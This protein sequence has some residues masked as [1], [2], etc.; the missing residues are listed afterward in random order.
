MHC[1]KNLGFELGRAPLSC[2]RSTVFSQSKERGIVVS[3]AIYHIS[4]TLVQH[5]YIRAINPSSRLYS[6]GY[7]T[8][9]FAS[10]F[11]HTTL[12]YTHIYLRDGDPTRTV[13]IKRIHDLGKGILWQVPKQCCNSLLIG[14]SLDCINPRLA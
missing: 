8:V 6:V 14:L 4:P 7:G 2:Q 3:T 1:K 10:M 9:S 11:G 5:L 12:H 13:H